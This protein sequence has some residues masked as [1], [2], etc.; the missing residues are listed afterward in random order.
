MLARLSQLSKFSR[1]RGRAVIRRFSRNEDGAAYT[2][3]Y[4]MVIPVYALLICLIIETC[5]ML[6]S[7]LGTVYA[8]YAAAR[9]ASVWSA[10]TTWD[11]AKKKAEKSAFHAMTPFASGTQ[12]G[13]F[14]TPPIPTLDSGAYI[15][16]YQLFAKTKVSSRYL[17]AKYDYAKR[18]VKVKIDGPPATPTADITAKVTYE[19]PFNVPG[20][21]ML[22]GHKGEGGRYYFSLTSQATIPNEGPRNEGNSTTKN[23]IGIGYG[24]LE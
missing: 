15:G 12:P 16:A 7:K 9:S 2:L 1:R 24:Q 11:K 6:T 5:M 3:S 21:G 17:L 22:L 4:V 10:H 18:H 13:R 20:I 19:F 23:S 8:A 14:G